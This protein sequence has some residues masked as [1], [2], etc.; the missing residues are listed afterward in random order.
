MLSGFGHLLFNLCAA[1]NFYFWLQGR[2][3]VM[4]RA[5][6]GL[7]TLCTGEAKP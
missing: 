5:C 4:D 6:A 7:S 1:F 2:R 3:V